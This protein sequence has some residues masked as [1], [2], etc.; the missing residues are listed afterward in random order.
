VRT[1]RLR[2]GVW[3]KGVSSDM[4]ISNNRFLNGRSGMGGVVITYGSQVE[5]MVRELIE[6]AGAM[7]RLRPDDTVVIKPNLVV[8]RQNWAGIDT[9]PR[10][11]EALV[12]SLKDRG[13]HRITIGDGSGMG[14]SATKAFD[15]C[16]YTELAACYGLR[17]VDL[18]RDRFIKKP[19]RMEGPFKNIEIA[20]TVLE[21]DF[22]INVPVMKAHNETLITCSLK[23]L[24][25]TLPRAMKTAFHGVNLHRAIAQLNSVLSPHLI[26]V[27][28]LQGDLHSET[29]HDPVVMERI[30]LGTNPVEVD[31]V[32]AETLGYAPRDIRHI[33]YSA[34]ASLGTCDLKRIRIRSLNRP[35]QRKRF[36]PPAHYSK[37]FPCTIRAEGVCCTCMGNF[38]F[39]LERLREKGLLSERISFLIGQNSTIPS[40]KKTLTVAVGKC[41]SKQDGSDLR[42]DECPPSAGSIFQCIASALKVG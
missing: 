29:G 6:N 2:D 14:Y 28:G 33:T 5:R 7:D 27:D 12:K 13:V 3:N 30:I 37:K 34:D 4:I 16:G 15:Y 31:S 24:K 19:V 18:E 20:R 42:I 10:V 22:F 26:I 1:L 41:A 8:S 11:I 23:N 32:V 39:A 17:L 21:C 35:S 9:D 40:G 38:I 25:G 36:R